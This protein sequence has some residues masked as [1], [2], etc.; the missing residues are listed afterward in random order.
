MARE[1]PA[2]PKVYTTTYDNFRGVDFTNDATNV[3]RRRS[4]TGV[5]MLPDE[6]GRPFKRHG[7]NILLSNEDICTAL[8]VPSCV[9]QKCSYFELAGVDHIV[10]FTDAGV[11]FYNGDENATAYTTVGVTAINNDD[12]D[13]YS[14]Y[15]R[16]FFFEGDGTSAF[17]IYGNF[18]MWRYEADFALHN[19]TDQITVPTVLFSADANCA[20]TMKESYN[21]LGT[22]ASVE[23]C[24]I[25]LFEYWCRDDII[26]NVDDTFKTTYAQGNPAFY[27]WNYDEDTSSWIPNP[28]NTT[29][30]FPSSL[31]TVTGTPVDGDT[32]IVVWAY[33]VMLPNNVSQNQLTDVKV[34]ASQ[35]TQFDLSLDVVGETDTI[36]ETM[37]H[38]DPLGRRAWIEVNYLKASNYVALVQG[39][40]FFKVEFPSVKI[41]ITQFTDEVSTT[42]TADLVGA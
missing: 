14:G 13:C 31:I 5:N 24:D 15:D 30:A 4:P 41:D 7:W 33:G 39:E 22:Q 11:L 2:A 17:Y 1:V 25:S 36:D 29:L 10:V 27:E 8:S 32:I 38:S 19:V 40:D 16:S 23:Y 20:G 6:S 18:K 9:I 42:T 12:Y 37:L 21:L 35:R 28:D 26:I 3:W 34:W